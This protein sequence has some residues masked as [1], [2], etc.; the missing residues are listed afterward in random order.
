MNEKEYQE[1]IDR[2]PRITLSGFKIGRRGFAR[3]VHSFLAQAE[4]AELKRLLPAFE[5]C[6]TYLGWRQRL[7]RGTQVSDIKSSAENWAWHPPF[8]KPEF[9]LGVVMLALISLGYHFRQVRGSYDGRIVRYH[10]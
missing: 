1:L 5:I 4:L 9:P 7:Q 6:C 8:A 3:S 2:H 10:G